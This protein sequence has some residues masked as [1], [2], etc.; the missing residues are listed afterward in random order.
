MYKRSEIERPVFKVDMQEGFYDR[1]VHRKKLF[2]VK[3]SQSHRSCLCFPVLHPPHLFSFPLGMTESRSVLFLSL[4]TYVFL[5]VIPA[6]AV[7]FCDK[8]KRKTK[9]IKTLLVKHY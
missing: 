3:R 9:L 8:R 2:H 6:D 7:L 4:Q 5:L 1:T